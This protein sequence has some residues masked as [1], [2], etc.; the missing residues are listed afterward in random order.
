MDDIIAHR[1]RR[2]PLHQTNF[3]NVT[4]LWQ[5]FVC[6]RIANDKRQTRHGM[7]ETETQTNE[8][9]TIGIVVELKSVRV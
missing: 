6:S 8:L 1:D 4:F 9:Y 2:Q 3:G 5:F 7:N